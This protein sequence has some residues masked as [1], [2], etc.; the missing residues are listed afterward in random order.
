MTHSKRISFLLASC[1]LVVFAVLPFFLVGCGTEPPKGPL[2][3]NKNKKEDPPAAKEKDAVAKEKDAVAKEKD[4]VA[5]EKDAT[6]KDAAAKDKDAAPKDKDDKTLLAKAN[7]PLVIGYSDWPGWLVLEIAKKKGFFKDAGVDVD[8]KYFDEYSASIDAYTGNKLDGILIACGDSLPAKSSVIIVLTDFSEG[9]DMIIGKK[10][11]DSIKDLKGKTVGLEVG[12]VEHMLLLK[13]LEDNGLK[14][15]D[16]TIS[17][18]ETTA[19]PGALKGGKVD[20][21]G[22]WYPISGRALK[23]VDGSK[24]L[25]TSKDAPGLIYDALQVDPESLKTRR[26]EWKKVVGVWFKCLDYLKDPNTHD[27]AVKMMAEKVAAKPEDMEK[28]LKGTH[29]L[30]GEGNMKAMRKRNTLDSIY[31]SLQTA[32]KFYIAHDVYK[33]PLNVDPFVDPTVVKEVLGK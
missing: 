5:K 18:M 20:A 27:E 33:K 9:N 13:A 23:E 28:N 2:T 1:S 6:E 7:K 25:F 10:G 19:T 8:L 16:V 32:D 22:A 21:V 31:G 24:A 15:S 17:K 12:L 26:D 11:V 30:D 3:E 4:A 29:L 14:E